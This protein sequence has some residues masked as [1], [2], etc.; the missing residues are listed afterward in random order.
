MADVDVDNSVKDYDFLKL[1]DSNFADL[2]GYYLGLWQDYHTLLVNSAGVIIGGLGLAWTSI[3]MMRSPEDKLRSVFTGLTGTCLMFLLLSVSTFTFP[4]TGSSVQMARGGGWSLTIVGNIYAIFKSA[5]DKVN[6]GKITEDAFSRAYHVTN[7]NTL[8]RFADSPVYPL[9]SDYLNKCE[10][11]FIAAN[12]KSP[13]A[14]SAGRYVGFFGSTGI[15]ANE[16]EFEDSRGFL[17][18]VT[19]NG[20][21]NY[22]NPTNSTWLKRDGGN[23][24]VEGT[25]KG[26]AMLDKI[27]G[28]SNPYDGTNPPQ[29]FEIPTEAYWVQK[30]FPEKAGEVADQA[31]SLDASDSKYKKYLNSGFKEAPTTGAKQNFYPKTCKDMFLMID[32]AQRN[33]NSAVQKH[34]PAYQENSFRRDG[35]DAAAIMLNHI[36]NEASQRKKGQS[37]LLTYG[38]MYYQDSDVRDPMT[39]LF[40]SGT[41]KFMDIGKTFREWMLTVKIPMMINGA[42]MLAALMGITF[43][44]FAVFG[45]FWS[46]R[47]IFTSVKIIAFCFIVAFVNDLCLTMAST[48][49]AVNAETMQGYNM[50]NYAQN[51]TLL[52]SAGTGQYIIF[53]AL[54]VIEI[55]FAK[56]LLWDDVK[57]LGGFNP[58]GATTGLAATGMAVVGAAIRIAGAALPGGI[59]GT[60][61]A[62]ASGGASAAGAPAGGNPAPGG[63]GG[64][65][66]G[67]PAQQKVQTAAQVAGGIAGGLGGGGGGQNGGGPGSSGANARS[68]VKIP[69]PQA[70]Q[71]SKGQRSSLDDLI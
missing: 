20:E 38:G 32:M 4:G 65:G 23:A 27:E 63:G 47:V 62:L 61:G 40:E 59:A 66:G 42:A 56:L 24:V 71:S 34:A 39:M 49:L 41:T 70:S 6:E 19:G 46:T 51:S 17:D 35:D 50:G 33:F 13:E 43:P 45:I 9:Y 69:T 54:T 22:D 1:V 15:G 21:A 57:S 53:V 44:I 52:I 28:D 3:L 55:I 37:E 5:L 30:L 48:M 11:A 12:G 64:S 26:M 58:A 29:G 7:Q 2:V 67:G 16:I 36:R 14:L 31:L 60:A 25:K 10:P 18:K 68:G 8:K